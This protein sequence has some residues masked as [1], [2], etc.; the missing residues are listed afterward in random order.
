MKP[1]TIKELYTACYTE[2]REFIDD[3]ATKYQWVGN[4]VFDL[5]TYDSALDEL[6]A[7]YIIEICKAI[8]DRRTFDYCSS[9]DIT[10]DYVKYILVCQKLEALNWIN[11]GTSIRGAWFDAGKDAKPILD[12]II[13]IERHG[14]DS[15]PFSIDNLKA[16]IEFVEEGENDE[17]IQR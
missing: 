16:L 1:K 6:F 14:V 17:R 15:I 9:S 5:V 3:E 4:E 13:D 12:R 7:K 2:F 10:E 8:L 11:W